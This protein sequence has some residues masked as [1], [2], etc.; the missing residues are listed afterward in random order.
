MSDPTDKAT[1]D[2]ADAMRIGAQSMS[3]QM[4]EGAASAQEMGKNAMDAGMAK[5]ADFTR[6]ALELDREVAHEEGR[7]GITDTA[8]FAYPTYARAAA[9]RRD[10]MRQSAA[11]LEGQLSE[12]KAELGEAFEDLKKIEILDDRERTAERAAEAARDQAAMDGIGL[13]RV[14]A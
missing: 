6:M 5:M 1:Q 9:A 4:Q 10:N 8:H 12:A 11:A 13:S 2:A 7:A 3:R 14:R